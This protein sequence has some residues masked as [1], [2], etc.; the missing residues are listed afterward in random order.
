M[1][2][3]KKDLNYY[4]NLPWQFE[5]TKHPDG[6]YSARVLGLS[7][8]SGGDTLEEA[9]KEIQEALQ[10]YIESCI[11]DNMPVVEPNDLG[12]ANGRIAIRTSKK[13]HL[14]LIQLAKEENVSISHLVNDAIIKTY[15]SVT[16]FV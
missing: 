1:T 5:F 7:C 8:Y 15:D 4:L 10:F 13:T 11:E 12:K 16:S 2:S 6:K 3:A 9:T 14:K